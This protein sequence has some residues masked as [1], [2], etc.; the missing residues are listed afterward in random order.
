ML[1]TVRYEISIHLSVPHETTW[2]SDW[3]LPEHVHGTMHSLVGVHVVWGC[4]SP[5]ER[6]NPDDFKGKTPS[7]VW[8]VELARAK[9]LHFHDG[10]GIYAITQE[11]VDMMRKGDRDEF[12]VIT[13]PRRLTVEYPTALQRILIFWGAN[14]WNGGVPVHRAPFLF[15]GVHLAEVRS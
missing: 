2:L 5:Y 9:V 6:W 14:E 7:S 11:D 8:I 1:L 12:A 13:I 4:A 15:G 10:G 3:N